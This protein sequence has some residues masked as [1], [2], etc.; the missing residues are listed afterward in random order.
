[1]IADLGAPPTDASSPFGSLAAR[2][3]AGVIDIGIVALLDWPVSRAVRDAGFASQLL[4][5]LL[6]TLYLVL[7]YT[8]VG[9]GQTVGK[10]LL[11]LRVVNARGDPL[12]LAASLRRWMVAVGVV[13]PLWWLRPVGPDLEMPSAL[14]GWGVLTAVLAVLAMDAWLFVANRPARRSLHDLCAGSFVVHRSATPPFR[15]APPGRGN[16]AACVLLAVLSGVVSLPLWRGSAVLAPRAV[17]LARVSAE[18]GRTPEIRRLMA[19]PSF[20]AMGADTTW[21][22]TIYASFATRRAGSATGGASGGATGGATGGDAVHALACAFARRAP[23]V[24]NH[25]DIVVLSRFAGEG[26]VPS[27]VL[28]AP[29]DLTPAA[30]APQ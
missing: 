21:R 26:T 13:W 27:G 10:R 20:S 19:W 2:C 16:V 8:R 24:V 4:M 12:S 25:G 23:R 29:E 11:R 17:Q 6:P 1:M 30:C 3:A 7:A 28:F 18:L 22:V 9:G 5:Q 14:V 15:A